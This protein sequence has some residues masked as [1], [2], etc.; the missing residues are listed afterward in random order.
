MRKGIYSVFVSVF[1]VF[2][3][4]ACGGGQHFSPDN[5]GANPLN[6]FAADNSN[7]EPPPGGENNLTLGQSNDPALENFVQQIH[8]DQYDNH[9]IVELENGDGISVKGNRLASAEERSLL[10]ANKVNAGLDKTTTAVLEPRFGPSLFVLRNAVRQLS[11]LSGR[12]LRR[13][14]TFFRVNISNRDQAEDFLRE[15]WKG[16]GIASVYPALRENPPGIEDIPDISGQQGYLGMYEETG[17]LS[18]EA[19]WE[20]GIRGAGVRLFDEEGGW[21]GDHEDIPES[22]FISGSSSGDGITLAHGAAVLGVLGGDDSD[23]HGIVGIATEADLRTSGL[24]RCSGAVSVIPGSIYLCEEQLPGPT[25]FSPMEIYQDVF[26]AFEIASAE[27]VTVIE[28]AANGGENMDLDGF[29]VWPGVDYTFVDFRAQDSGA[30][31]VGAAYGGTTNR[32]SWSNCGE[33]VDVYAWG[34]GVVTTSYP[35]GEGYGWS[36]P[37][38]HP[39]MNDPSR[40]ETY[41]T[42]QFGGTSSA[43][44]IVAGAAALLQSYAKE[45]MGE[46]KYLMPEQMRGLLA[47]SGVPAVTNS[48]CNIGAQPRMDVA[49]DLFDDFWADIES[50]FPEL[51]A[52]ERLTAERNA[53][54]RAR[55]VGLDCRLYDFANSDPSCPETARCVLEEEYLG[56]GEELMGSACSSIRCLPIDVERSELGCLA[57][58]IWPSGLRL[59]KSLDFDGDGKA[60]LVNWTEA[61]GWRIDLSATGGGDGY[62]AWDVTVPVPAISARWVWPVAEDYNSDGRTDI[63]VYDKEHGRW[64]IKFTDLEV[65]AGTWTGWDWTITL[66]YQDVL[67]L[68]PWETSYARPVPGDYNGD[69]YVD[70]AITRSDGIWSIDHGG[71]LRSDYGAFD[72]NVT[73][74]TPGQLAEAPGW[75][76]LPVQGFGASNGR[77]G[78]KVPDGIPDEGEV[79]TYVGYFRNQNEYYGI[80]PYGGNNSIL[81]DLNGSDFS[82]KRSD[83]SWPVL[84]SDLILEPVPPA[85]IYGG[86]D[87]H[88]F[89]ADFDGD[90][91]DDR[92]VQCPT[93]FRIGLSSTGEARYVRLGYN[94]SAFSLPGKPYFGSISYATTL[95]IIDFQLRSRPTTPPTIPVDMVSGGF[96][97]LPW[98]P[99]E[100]PEECR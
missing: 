65:L 61:G 62:G 17:G 2:L 40:P 51:A 42:N 33:R 34:S 37:A 97:A 68:D 90:G 39:Y 36:G 99:G 31:M 28:P 60:E 8:T 6:F 93:E 100:T 16:E 55:G 73:Y 70:L 26:A 54:L 86:L 72:Q 32:A 25:G 45:A 81:F 10:G 35:A 44:A 53:A 49:L 59:G 23:T 13:L 20:R 71:P 1:G 64:H 91:R 52:G 3:F 74:L 79:F 82:V 76:C 30:I 19:A 88:P 7:D 75:A 48:D 57:G 85:D 96:C 84:S 18:I 66:P 43:S 24:N 29:F 78:Y 41:Y 38:P 83:G 92:A 67:R 22:P 27:G 14:D 94:T 77:I 46:R 47:G 12:P 4:S 9:V 21:Y 69:G 95:Q 5:S 11:A 98:S 80:L 50:D 56:M 15:T 63:A 89:V 58:V 87:C